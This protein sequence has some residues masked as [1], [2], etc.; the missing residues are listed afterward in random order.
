MDKIALVFPGQGTQYVGMGESFY[1]NYL[2][3]R[4]TYEEA[5]DISGV[6][7]AQLCFK[8]SLGA[9]SQIKNMQLSVVT[10]CVAI[11]RAYFYEYGMTPQFCAGH[12][13]GEIAAFIVSGAI[14]FSDGIQILMKRGELLEEVYHQHVGTMLIAEEIDYSA[15][16]G[17]IEGSK[18]H[19]DVYISCESSHNQ[20]LLSGTDEGIEMIQEKLLDH[21][22]RI[23]PLITSTPMHCPLMGSIEKT[24]Y[25][26]LCGFEFYPFRI[27]V[28]T[29]LYGTPFSDPDLIPEVMS[30]HL[31]HPVKWKKI[32]ECMD[33]YGVSIALEMGPKNLVTNLVGNIAPDMTAYCFGKKMDRKHFHEKF[34]ADES[35]KKDIPDFMSR[36]LGIAVA[37]KNANPSTEAYQKGVVDNYNAIKKIQK[38][39]QD[40]NR[41]VLKTDMEIALQYL[42]NIMKTKMV[43]EN[44]QKSW[45]KR[46]L[47]ETS[48]YYLL[49]E[50]YV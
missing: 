22:A 21:Q 29:N 39:I 33:K 31:T 6:D 12:S 30:K 49:K 34:I 23:T 2:V 15:V 11:A 43:P 40:T 19:K 9:L 4:Q 50:Y 13:V 46:L 42:E 8:S 44:E 47:D 17:L 18:L 35:Y 36:C 27:P 38:D 5:S 26:Y 48:H 45:I 24:F 25:D 1:N 3:C 28:I 32:I 14:G 37:T 16:E 10:T 7:V 20:I 41:K